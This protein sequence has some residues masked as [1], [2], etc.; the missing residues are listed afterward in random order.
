MM[1]LLQS[2]NLL[3]RSIVKLYSTLY[4]CIIINDNQKE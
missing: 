2:Y 4:V 1:Y 3:L